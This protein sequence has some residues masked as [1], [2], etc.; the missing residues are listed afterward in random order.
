MTRR[1]LLHLLTAASP[2]P[3]CSSFLTEWLEAAVPEHHSSG[4]APPEPPYWRDYKPK[5]FSQTDFEALEA[6]TEILIPTDQTPGARDAH[7][8][9]FIDFLLAATGGYAPQTQKQWLAA[10]AQLN[11]L[12]FQGGDSKV[13]SSI[14]EQISLPERDRSKKH[15]A[16][17]A[18]LRI[19]RE[20]AFAFYTSR[21]GMIGALDYKG[22]T[23]NA[24]FPG[25]QHPEHHAL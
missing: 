6:M 23:Y 12:G 2:L 16:F 22:N 9:H 4:T 15:P 1:S 11:E 14:V 17:A 20:N 3:A 24:V 7:C 13:R 5:F 25:C 8:A 19:K 21:A 18:Y 10:M